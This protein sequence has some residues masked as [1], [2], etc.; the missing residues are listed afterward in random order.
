MLTRLV[1]G[2]VMLLDGRDRSVAPVL[3]MD[4]VWEPDVTQVVLR[5][6]RPG[7][8]VLDV[9]ANFGYFTLLLCRRVGTE[10]RVYAFEPQARVHAFL[11]Y[12]IECNAYGTVA[13]AYRLALGASAGTQLL[14]RVESGLGVRAGSASVREEVA[15]E[16]LP[17]VSEAVLAQ[18]TA[19]V[20]RLDDLGLG[21]I[22][23][24]KIDA[25][26]AEYD[27]WR[28]GRSTLSQAA[29]L[30]MEYGP[31]SL[32]AGPALLEELRDAGFRLA[33]IERGGRLTAALPPEIHSV[34]EDRGF[35]HVFA[36]K[37][38]YLADLGLRVEKAKL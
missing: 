5:C 15:R 6:V 12:N 35:V 32:A 18:E 31:R 30:I 38:R 16:L 4:G 34:A 37:P 25:E 26:G 33:I 3:I 29:C 19:E 21:E 9:G 13:R 11:E 7:M 36:G 2:E 28:G 1:S 8:R 17:A 24:A 14:R 23:F 10:G 22:D 20:T 27:V